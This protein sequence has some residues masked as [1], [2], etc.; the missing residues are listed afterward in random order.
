MARV[1][2]ATVGAIDMATNTAPSTLVPI[3]AVGAAEPN[4]A[5]AAALSPRGFGDHVVEPAADSELRGVF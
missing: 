4:A 1:V 2:G 5:G 3:A